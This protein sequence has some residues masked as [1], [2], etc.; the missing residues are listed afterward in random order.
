M[1]SSRIDSTSGHAGKNCSTV[2]PP[3]VV[4]LHPPGREFPRI[5]SSD[6]PPVLDGRT[7]ELFPSWK[8][9]DK[10][11]AHPL[12]SMM[13]RAG[14][15]PPALARYLILGYS[16]PGDL[17][18]DPFCGKGTTLLEAVLCGRKAWGCDVAPDAVA[19]TRA[20]LSSVTFDEVE[21]YL[22]AIRRV[23]LHHIDVPGDVRVFFHM[24]TLRSTLEIM[25]A[26]LDD[27]ASESRRRGRVATYLIGCI[28]GI[29][30][31]HASHSLSLSSSHAYAMAPRYVRKYARAHGLKR[32]VRDAVQCLKAKSKVLLR[33]GP[34]PRNSARVHRCSAEKYIFNRGGRLDDQVDLIVTS[35]PYLNAQ[36]YAKD[37]WL[38][39]WFLGHDYRAIR[40]ALIE[41][42]SP[43][44][45][46]ERMQPCMCEMLNVLKPGHSAF[47]VAGDVFVTRG[48]R[49][50]VVRTAELLGDVA[51]ELEPIRG[52]RF[53]I[54][55]V[56]EDPIADHSRYYFSVHGG[57]GDKPSNI[58]GRQTPQRLDRVVH[59]RKVPLD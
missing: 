55:K 12:H 3:S 13:A 57:D 18:L 48:Q 47:I 39:L 34:V 19:A 20:K 11:S 15:F 46:V 50:C 4:G 31:G 5:S 32:P 49:K 28:L 40:R 51:S 29:L 59:L 58:V 35:P 44:L 16:D 52:Y 30:H 24:K 8:S 10:R 33:Q 1:N 7:G 56:I 43:D 21:Q 9:A 26:L 53:R 14:S 37:A 2:E 27:A 36:T 42:G 23:P 38:R 45:Y 22:D 25:P 6:L 41:T 17:I 54:E